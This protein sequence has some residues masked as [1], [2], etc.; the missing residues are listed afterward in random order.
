MLLGELGRLGARE[1]AAVNGGVRFAGELALSYAVNLESR[2]ASRVL[3]Q[4]S[5]QPYRSE[6]DIFEAAR[7]LPWNDWFPVTHAIRVDVSAIRA[8]VKSLDFVTLRVKDAVCDAFR[9][10]CGSRPDVDTRS[11]DVRIQVFL[12]ATHCTIYLDTSGEPLFKR[13][14]RKEA[15]DAPLRE[16]LAAGILALSGWDAASPLLDPMCGS[17]TFLA[18]AAM[19]A[20]DRAPGL[21]RAFG[22]EKL[23]SFDAKAWQKLLHAARM[24]VRRPDTLAI[25]GSDR[26]GDALKLARA[27]LV[28][29]D[30]ASLV[31]L[32]QADVLE[33]PPPEPAGVI[34]TNPPY[35]VRL[36]DQQALAELYPKL[37]DALKKKYAGW[38]AYIFTADLRL[39]KLIGLSPSRRTPLYN[40]ALECRLF[41]FRLVAGGMR[42]RQPV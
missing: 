30:V 2:I 3:W 17:G 36:Q 33:M 14:Y 22:F 13:G 8:P 20:I 26:Y 31:T 9:E 32:K 29:L 1:T 39:A 12:S 19:I 42:R 38:T 10:K 27:N 34:V 35:G 5:H 21:E 25:Y 16:N 37:G 18:E 6:R 23:S 40:G 11:P 41:E 7:K 15:G 4:V 28:A 24:R